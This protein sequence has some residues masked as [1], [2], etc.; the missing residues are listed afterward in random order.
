[1]KKVWILLAMAVVL[2]A[3]SAGAEPPSV[4]HFGGQVVHDN[5][6]F[7]I[8]R[9]DRFEHRWKDGDD[10]FLWDVDAWI[11]GDF[12]KLYFKSEGE[13][14]DD[15]EVEEAGAELFYNRTIST[16]WDLQ[17]GLRHDFEPRPTRTFA[18]FGVQG[19]A[20]YWF[21]VDATAYISDDGD[22]SAVLEAEYDLLLSQRLILQPRFETTVA[23][24]E[25][26]EYGVGSGFN[27]IELGLRLR[28]E[29]HRKFAPYVGVSWI[30]LLGETADFAESE[31]DDVESV[32]WVAGIRFWF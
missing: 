20:P 21:E 14:L 2:L 6:I 1:M 4:T 16:F 24:Q 10:V 12:H 29:I 32:S 25:V 30:Q 9:A 8:L 26:P 5:D 23:L 28:Y 31:G 22:V 11:G 19:L 18:A 15:G 27:D 13:M 17:I 3:G 7:A